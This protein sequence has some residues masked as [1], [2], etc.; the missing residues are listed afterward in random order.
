MQSCD[1]ALP[2]EDTN[3][4]LVVEARWLIEELKDGES[5]YR[6]YEMVQQQEE[7]GV[8]ILGAESLPLAATL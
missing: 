7:D 4:L 1:S 3:S 6:T 5:N 2:G 8:V